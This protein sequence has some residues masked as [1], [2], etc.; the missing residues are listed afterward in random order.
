VGATTAG[1]ALTQTS[2]TAKMVDRVVSCSAD[3]LQAQDML[4][5]CLYWIIHILQFEWLVPTEVKGGH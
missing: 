1:M 5:Q 4:N 3:A 2:T